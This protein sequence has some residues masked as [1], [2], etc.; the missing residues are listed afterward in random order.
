M[1]FGNNLHVT[2]SSY[3][4]SLLLDLLLNFLLNVILIKLQHEDM[5]A[6]YNGT[7]NFSKKD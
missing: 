3:L 6:S 7:C 5:N 1:V 4:N 2:V